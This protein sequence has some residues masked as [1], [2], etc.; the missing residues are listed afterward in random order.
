L[1]EDRVTGNSRGML[2]SGAKVLIDRRKPDGNRVKSFTIGG[3][4][5]DP[6]KI[7]R[8]AVSDYLAEGNSGFDRLTQVAP[9][10]IIFTGTL[11]RQ[12]MIDYVRKHAQITS[13]LDGR[14]KEI[15]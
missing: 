14:W 3:K 15:K 5:I 4:P 1:I 13:T 7:Y 9:E 6:K 11:L 10:H 12:T 2:V 8:L